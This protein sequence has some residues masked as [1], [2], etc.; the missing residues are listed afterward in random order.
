MANHKK[1][2]QAGHAASSETSHNADKPVTLKDMLGADILA[3]LKEQTEAMKQEEA[4]Q[5]ETKRQEEE[6]KRIAE[7]KLKEKD[8]EYLLNNSSPKDWRKYN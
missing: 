8:F 6:A 2:K 7:Q 4:S 1:K 5:R 3:K